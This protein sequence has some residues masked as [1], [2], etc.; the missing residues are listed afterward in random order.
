MEHV[1]E[2]ARNPEHRLRL[3]Q[4]GPALARESF[5]P[6]SIA[7]RYEDIYLELNDRRVP[8][9]AVPVAAD[10]GSSLRL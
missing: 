10:A 1:A 2:L 5:A 9:R 7:A 8:A 3:G 6:E 4:N